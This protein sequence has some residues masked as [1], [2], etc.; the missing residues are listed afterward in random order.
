MQR[1]ELA[2][3]VETALVIQVSDDGKDIEEAER[4]SR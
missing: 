4:Q 2:D 1:C 3:V